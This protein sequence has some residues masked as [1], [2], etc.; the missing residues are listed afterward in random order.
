MITL[1]NTILSEV[2]RTAFIRK[3]EEKKANYNFV[4]PKELIIKSEKKG[5]IGKRLARKKQMRNAKLK[6]FIQEQQL[7]QK[8][9][10]N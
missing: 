4:K 8:K 6:E 3:Q 2:D 10:K 5:K 1:D 7:K 9:T